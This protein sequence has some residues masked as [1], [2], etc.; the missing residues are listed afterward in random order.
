MKTADLVDDHNDDVEF[1]HLPF[2]KFGRVKAFHGPIQTVQSFEDNV[3]L[4]AELSQPGNGRVLV[5]DG[6]GSTRLAILGDIIAG[7]LQDNDWAGI[8]INGA[9]RDSAEVDEMDVAVYCLG[10]SPK[11]SA[12]SGAG[13]VGIPI[14]FGGVKFNPGDWVYADADGVLV[15]DKKLSLGDP[16]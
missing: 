7:I 11:K 1:C 2:L 14:Q 6:G 13:S 4:K 9:I 5:V 8:I 3:L 15:A 10:T 16:D 12:K